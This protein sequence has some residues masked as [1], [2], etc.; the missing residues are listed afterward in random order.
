M[1]KPVPFLSLRLI[2]ARD[3]FLFDPFLPPP[4]PLTEGIGVT[5]SSTGAGVGTGTGEFVIGLSVGARVAIFPDVGGALGSTTGAR[6]GGSEVSVGAAVGIP[7][8]S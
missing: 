4:F 8:I 7:G 1:A 3:L 5:G 6:V 2:A